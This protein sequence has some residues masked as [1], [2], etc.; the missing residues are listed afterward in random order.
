MIPCWSQPALDIGRFTLYFHGIF[1]ALGTI[2]ASAVFVQRARVSSLGA[3]TALLLLLFLIPVGFLGS[4]LMYVAFEDHGSLFQPQGISSLGGILSCLLVI[5][6]FV[7]RRP[8]RWL[9]AA[10]YAALCGALIARLGCFLAHDRIGLPASSWLSVNCPGGPYYDLAFFELIFLAV[11]LGWSSWMQRYRGHPA[12]GVVFAVIAVS[13]GCFRLALGQLLYMPRHYFGL[14]SE[15]W[16]AAS[17]AVA[18]GACFWF[19]LRHRSPGPSA[20]AST[21]P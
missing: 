10:S 8:S 17:L 16:G 18:A 15:Q 12:R 4:H 7:V 9:D 19:F 3:R 2:V 5:A 21:K 14:A 6:C 20:A 1:L 11:L 13:Y